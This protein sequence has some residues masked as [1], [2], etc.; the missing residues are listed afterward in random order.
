MKNWLVAVTD[1][2]YEW[3]RKMGKLYDTTSQAILRAALSWLMEQS[4]ELLKKEIERNQLAAALDTI[5]Q[6][7]LAVK[8][9]KTELQ[10]KL[11]NYA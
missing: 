9:K 2:H 8:K 7:E 1:E 5:K 11:T 10:K 3:T 4:P 6:Q